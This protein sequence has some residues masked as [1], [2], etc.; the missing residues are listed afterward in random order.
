MIQGGLQDF[1]YHLEDM[2][3]LN[4]HIEEDMEFQ[5]VLNVKEFLNLLRKNLVTFSCFST[6]ETMF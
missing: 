1:L 2:Q 6:F 4:F 5:K 3:K